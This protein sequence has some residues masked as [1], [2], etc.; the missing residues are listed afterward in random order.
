MVFTDRMVTIPRMRSAGWFLVLVFIGLQLKVAGAASDGNGAKT[1]ESAPDTDSLVRAHPFNDSADPQ[2]QPYLIT[3]MVKIYDAASSSAR[4][5]G[6]LTQ[7]HVMFARPS[8][9]P[10]WLQIHAASEDTFP[11]LFQGYQMSGRSDV[12]LKDGKLE[13]YPFHDPLHYYPLYGFVQTANLSA[14]NDPAP[15][16]PV[17]A[18]DLVPLPSLWKSSLGFTEL[19][20][21]PID[22]RKDPFSAVVLVYVKSGGNIVAEC[23]GFFLE[24]RLTVASAGHCFDKTLTKV[25][26][27]GIDVVLGDKSGA[28]ETIP[29]HLLKSA[30]VEARHGYYDS[31]AD[32]DFALL[33]VDHEPVMRVRPLSL[34][35]AGR[36]TTA[37][38]QRVMSIGYGADTRLVK[39]SMGLPYYPTVSTC[40]LMSPLFN[41]SAHVFT[42][43]YRGDCIA[44]QGD[45]GGPMVIWNQDSARY[46]VIGICSDGQDGAIDGF[47]GLSP[48]AKQMVVRTALQTCRSLG[49]SI[50]QSQDDVQKNVEAV[51]EAA[52]IRHH[53]RGNLGDEPPKERYVLNREFVDAVIEATG[54][55]RNADE[56]FKLFT[57]ERTSFA[58]RF[59]TWVDASSGIGFG[60]REGPAFQREYR[61]AFVKDC[62]SLPYLDRTHQ[63]P[64]G[65]GDTMNIE[66]VKQNTKLFRWWPYNEPINDEQKKLLFVLAGGDLFIVQNETGQIYFV[67]R[68]FMNTM[69]S[70][71]LARYSKELVFDGKEDQWDRYNPKSS[72]DPTELLRSDNFDAETPASIPGGKAVSQLQA[73]HAILEGVKNPQQK[74]VVLSAM[75]DD[76]GLPT[77]RKLPDV[78]SSR[79]SYDDSSEATLARAMKS[80]APDKATPLIVYSQS[81]SS[82][83]SYNAALR[84][85]H[86]GYTDVHWMKPGLLGWIEYTLPL[87]PISK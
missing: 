28:I 78:A 8:I 13:L 3:G 45:S 83:L 86:L 19:R 5:T 26:V 54:V 80:I 64:L 9:V 51:P 16:L 18:A 77:A 84:L 2:E 31:M 63:L 53:V 29:A 11:Y 14:F 46:E 49:A 61:A 73:L 41:A 4:I 66:Q 40:E 76:L 27:D 42:S 34:P 37:G 55:S 24:N 44:T 23:T 7:F 56:I 85:I 79:G 59:E 17:T 12:A 60:P 22:P 21:V 39:Q 36:W 74:P 67:V 20:A 6:D 52:L 25:Q 50:C 75:D 82:W 33:R 70:A 10:G 62:L 48:E 38:K 30:F 35:S 65:L 32:L 87:S 58:K 15:P 72:V 57:N 43:T 71:E 69:D 47:E 1:T 81:S 68:N